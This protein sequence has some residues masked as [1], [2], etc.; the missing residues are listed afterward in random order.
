MIFLTTAATN[1]NLQRLKW[2]NS[3]ATY[4]GNSFKIIFRKIFIVLNVKN[5]KIKIFMCV[6]WNAEI[7]LIP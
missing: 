2:I 6:T 3:S 7:L 5:A 4:A 1:I